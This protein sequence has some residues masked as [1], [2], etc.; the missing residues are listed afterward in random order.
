MTMICILNYCRLAFS[1]DCFNTLS[2]VRSPRSYTPTYDT[3]TKLK[4]NTLYYFTSWCRVTDV[5]DEP[6]TSE[7]SVLI[8]HSTLL[9]SQERRIFVSIALRTSVIINQWQGCC[10]LQTIISCFICDVFASKTF[11]CGDGPSGFRGVEFLDS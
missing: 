7:M 3:N 8:C 2:S 10:F 11:E 5:L 1:T 9:I 6:V 4:A